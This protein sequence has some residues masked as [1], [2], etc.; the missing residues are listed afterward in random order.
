MKNPM[1]TAQQPD[2]K[3]SSTTEKVVLENISSWESKNYYD[4][5]GVSQNATQEEI[6][7]AFRKLSSKYHPDTIH[8]NENLR[9]NYEEVQKLIGEA[10]TAL[11]NSKNTN[12][13]Y[14]YT[15]TESKQSRPRTES[16]K[17]DDFKDNVSEK[18]NYN[19]QYGF[20][21]IKKMMDEYVREGVTREDLLK[22]TEQTFLEDFTKK[23]K[24]NME[25]EWSDLTTTDWFQRTEETMEDYF[26][27]GISKEKLLLS[28]ESV[29]LT[30]F[31]KNT[32]YVINMHDSEKSAFPKVKKFVED[33]SSLGIEKEKLLSVAENN[34]YKG[35][36]NFISITVGPMSRQYSGFKHDSIKKII[37]DYS[38]LGIDR[39][40]LLS[41]AKVY[42]IEV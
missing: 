18:I 17:V 19:R 28:I 16:E 39:E 11:S 40:K 20:I 32:E 12:E 8:N 27:L 22:V 33:F 31:S 26:S 21:E 7:K 35:L 34:I 3:E 5:L 1:E 36:S 38:S 13:Q 2:I 37:D 10:Y 30:N 24:E 23:T 15:N 9:T 4:R 25:S 41:I 29:V 14:Q 6:K 42:G